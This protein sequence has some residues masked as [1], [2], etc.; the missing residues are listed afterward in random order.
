M[1][2]INENPTFDI[3]IACSLA[4]EEREERGQEWKDLLADAEEVAELAEGYA[5]RFPNRDTWIRQATEL[6]IAE[7]RCCPFFRFSLAFEANEG[8]VWLHIEGSVELRAFIRKEMVP[9][10][11]GRSG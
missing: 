8:P 9:S 4:A 1:N 6:I 10:H 7:R 11:L 2:T 5:L 3:D